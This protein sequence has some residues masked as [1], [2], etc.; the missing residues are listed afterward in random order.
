MSQRIGRRVRVADRLA[1]LWR[2]GIGSSAWARAADAALA[3]FELMYRGANALYHGAYDTG[4]GRVYRASVPVVSVGNLVVG[5]AGK[6]PVA[7]WLVDRLIE[8]G[9]RPA[10][11]HGGYGSD[12]PELHRRRRA[13]VPVYAGRDRAASAKRAIAA[14]A[15]VLVLDDGF[16][17][18]R[19]ARDLDLVLIPVEWWTP[20][21]RLLPRGPWREPLRALRRADVIGITRKTAT[22]TQASVVAG[23]IDAHAVGADRVRFALRPVGWRTPDGTTRSAGPA[24][25]AVAVT[26]IA[27]P[28]LFEANARETGAVIAEAIRL[29]DHYAY[30]PA[31]AAGLRRLAGG[32]PIVTTAKDAVKLG[33]LAPDL[34][35]WVLQQEVA[36]EVGHEVL[37]RW[38]DGLAP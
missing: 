21:P 7:G 29:R 4:H 13:D 18:R 19:M 8:R 23:E 37:N 32:R 10:I 27:R 3:P 22:A 20:R 30:G 12:E 2:G 26:A 17:H 5:G 24:G 14:G 34:P 1:S 15:S 11:L 31:D 33:E 6:T 25:P 38:M 35:L 36:V 16:Q 28:D 9:L